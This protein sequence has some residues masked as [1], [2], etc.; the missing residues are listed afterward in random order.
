MRCNTQVYT[1]VLGFLVVFRCSIMY[2]RFW[3]GRTNIELMTSKWSIAAMQCVTFGNYGEDATKDDKFYMGGKFQTTEDRLK[4]RH[5]ILS[6]FS[7]LNATALARQRR[8]PS[9]S[10]QRPEQEL[11][12]ANTSHAMQ[13]EQRDV[14]KG[15]QPNATAN[16]KAAGQN[17]PQSPK[18]ICPY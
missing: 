15:Q 16:E 3:E 11:S 12:M 17:G 13:N 14:K 5:R 10:A 2:T 8:Y 6:L 4:F 1:S 9:P 18:F 7:L